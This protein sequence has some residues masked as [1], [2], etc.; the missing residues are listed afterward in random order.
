MK[1][2][3]I[4]WN[5]EFI[6]YQTLLYSGVNPEWFYACIR[7]EIIVPAYTGQGKQYFWTNDILK[8]DKIIPIY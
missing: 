4:D 2:L 8:A 3:K 1:N 7:N 6:E 5:N